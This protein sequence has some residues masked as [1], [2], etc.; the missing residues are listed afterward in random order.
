MTDIEKA[1][2]EDFNQIILE[3]WCKQWDSTMRLSP[4]I[5]GTESSGKFL[6]TSPADAMMLI[7]SMEASFGDVSGPM[8]IAVPYYTLEPVVS[9]LLSMASAKDDKKSVPLRWHGAYDEIPVDVSAEWDAF[10]LTLR[11]LSNLEVDGVIEM[12]P[13]LIGDTKLRIEN[14]TC[15]IGEIGLEGD[16]VAFQVNESI[17]DAVKLIG[18]IMDSKK[19][20]IV[21]GVKVSVTVQLGTAELPMKEVVELSP[22]A[23]IQ[24][25]QNAK[26]P[27]SLL[28]NGKLIAHGEVVVV[29]DK[30]GLKI[31]E[32]VDSPS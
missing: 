23:Q 12:S 18:K 4:S 3:E 26:D 16:Q 5:I 9:R 27:V 11:D 20:D 24:L 19:M 30:F 10:E 1:L 28:V 21:M 29:D 8:R 7:L 17:A 6:Q 15:F 31:T 14:R 2:V 22:G 13:S 32:I 25:K